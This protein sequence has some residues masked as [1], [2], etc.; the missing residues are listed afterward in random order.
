MAY[1]RPDGQPCAR[2]PTY[3]YTRDRWGDAQAER[4]ISGMFEAFERIQAHGVVS[5]PNRAEFD[6]EGFFFRY[7]H[8]LLYWRR[9]SDDDVGIVTTLHERRHQIER[10]K[11]D[12]A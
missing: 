1:P 5:R 12:F 8:H 10:F 11:G 3:R 7:E 2:G 9:L 4:Y 6:V